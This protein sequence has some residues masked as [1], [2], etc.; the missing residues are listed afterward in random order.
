MDAGMGA[1]AGSGEGC[2]QSF[3]QRDRGLI[4]QTIRGSLLLLSLL[5]SL[6]VAMAQEQKPLSAIPPDNF[7]ITETW[8]CEGIFRGAQVHKATFTGAV[9]LADKWLELTEQDV[10][11]ATGYTAKYLIGYDRTQ[12]SLVEFDANNL[13][14]ATYSS[15]EGW[16][17]RVLTMTSVINQDPKTSFAANRFLYSI[18]G[19]D[20][21]TV[22]WQ[23]SRTADLNWTQAD[24]LACK[25]RGEI[26]NRSTPR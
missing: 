23:I 15:S 11:P 16:K 5:A 26:R 3:S 10:Q 6:P 2:E 14:A 1:A 17:N 4:M 24:H 25:R 9:I 20:T 7:Q 19:Q 13:G 21:F 8:D 12:K 18:T 22:D